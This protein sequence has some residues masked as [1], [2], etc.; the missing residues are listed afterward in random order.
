MVIVTDADGH[1]RSVGVAITFVA[2]AGVSLA[3]TSAVT[4]NNG[5]ASTKATFG[6]KAGT[7]S[8]TATAAG[9]PTPPAIFFLTATPG[10]ASA[11]VAEAGNN[12]S[13]P[14]GTD[15][16]LIALVTD[17]YGNPVPDVKVDWTAT[18][19]SLAAVVPADSTGT[20]D[21]VLQLPP[22]PTTVTATATI[23][24]TAIKASFIDMSM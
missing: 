18:A 1:G 17:Q 4:D 8:V 12:Q 11:I 14:V 19:G 22:T 3:S 13:A 10:P 15:V 2:S 6:T 16:Q 21:D 23:D 7:D 9:L 24:G 5:L 20:A